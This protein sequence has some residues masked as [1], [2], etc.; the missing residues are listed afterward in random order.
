MHPLIAVFALAGATATPTTDLF[1]KFDSAAMPEGSSE[2][3]AQLVDYAAAHPCAKIVID[4][5]AD[6]TGSDQ[7]NVGLS[8]RR[9]KTIQAQLTM[10]GV[11]PKRIVVVGHGEEGVRLGD[12]SLDRRVSVST[13]NKPLKS[14]IDESLATEAASVTWEEPVQAASIDG[15][16][17]E[18]RTQTAFR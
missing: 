7:Y 4:G 11:N 14:I 8:L 16:R 5:N 2:K 12:D 15:P 9:A 18:T 3:L 10:L 6:S 13:T 17:T 1:F